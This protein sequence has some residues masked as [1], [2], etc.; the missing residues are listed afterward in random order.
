VIIVTIQETDYS[1]H[2]EHLII[3]G[4]VETDSKI[5]VAAFLRAVANIYDPPKPTM[6]RNDIHTRYRGLYDVD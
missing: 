6:R 4:R 1:D 3:T 2:E 5:A